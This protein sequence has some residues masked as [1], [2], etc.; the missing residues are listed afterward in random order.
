MDSAKPTTLRTIHVASLLVLIFVSSSKTI[1]TSF[2]AAANQ[3]QNSQWKPKSSGSSAVFPVQ[4]NVYPDGVYTV[5]LKIGKRPQPYTLDIDTGSDLTWLQCD[6]PCVSCTKKPP[7][8]YKPYNNFVRCNDAI[9]TAVQT[10][11]NDPCAD[12]QGQCD[13]EVKYVDQGTS[14]GVLVAD[15][16]QLQFSNGSRLSPRLVFGCGYDQQLPNS[17]NP[18]ITDG[19]LGLGAGKSSI[20]SQLQE[21]GLT[22]HVFGHCFSGQGGGFLFFGDKIVPSLGVIWVPM[23]ST[24]HSIDTHYSLGPA[25]LLFDG[26]S[27][28]AKGLLMIFDSGSSYTYFNAIAYQAALS[29]VRKGLS[30]KPLKDAVEDQSLPICWKSAKPFK[31]VQ[32]VKSYFKPLQLKYFKTK[33]AQL[34]IPPEAYLVITKHGNVCLGILNGTEVGLDSLNV[35]G[36]NFF[37]DKLVV[38]SNEKQ[39]IEMI[40]FIVMARHSRML[41]R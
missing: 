8:L 6:A 12:A 5:A 1:F 25:E 36:D 24:G 28:G 34:E 35:I 21:M 39:Q 4:G 22:G 14:L 32:D 19:V 10:N 13:Y 30:G 27:T 38:Y 16:F 15:N 31:S 7:D 40:K 11:K 3:A 17:Q 26:H 37:Q 29:A 23:A 18:P 20:V 41:M 9:C 33:N 2:A